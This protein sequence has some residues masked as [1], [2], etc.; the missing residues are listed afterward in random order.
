M[1]LDICLYIKIRS[2]ILLNIDEI[3]EKLNTKYDKIID[4]CVGY[5]LWMSTE[6]NYSK[7]YIWADA[8]TELCK[9]KIKSSKDD[10]WYNTKYIW[11]EYTLD[12]DDT[13]W[14]ALYQQKV[15]GLGEY[16]ICYLPSISQL[17]EIYN[18]N[19]I[20]K[21]PKMKY[22]SSSQYSVYEYRAYYADFIN[23]K[24]NSMGKAVSFQCI[25]LLNFE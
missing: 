1:V 20:I 2:F 3:S 24:I 17:A 5:G 22:W 8:I 14:D 19:D 9:D 10:G 16:G 21:L 15:T 23:D 11:N 6:F 18:N 13:I 4:M 12:T 25:A 7:K